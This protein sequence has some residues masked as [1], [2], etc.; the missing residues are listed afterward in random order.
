MNHLVLT[1]HQTGKKINFLGTTARQ[2][3]QK[4]ISNFTRFRF[5]D[6]V[7]RLATK[8]FCLVLSFY[9]LIQSSKF[10]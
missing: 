9:P 5:N 4:F 10:I 2:K 6:S 1:L 3:R 7:M 8:I